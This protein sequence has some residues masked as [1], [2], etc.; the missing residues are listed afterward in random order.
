MVNLLYI[1]YMI[2][3]LIIYIVAILRPLIVVTNLIQIL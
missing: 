2:F 1:N 3:I